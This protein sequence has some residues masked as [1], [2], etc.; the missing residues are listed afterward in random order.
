MTSVDMGTYMQY[1]W[2]QTCEQQGEESIGD[3]IILYRQIVTL[4]SLIF[5]AIFLAT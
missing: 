5:E 2:V 3:C 4:H 1:R